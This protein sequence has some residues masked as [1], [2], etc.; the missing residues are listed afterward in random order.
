MKEVVQKYLDNMLTTTTVK[1][2]DEYVLGR[3]VNR[4][5][6]CGLYLN[7]TKDSILEKVEI[8]AKVKFKLECDPENYSQEIRVKFFDLLGKYIEEYGEPITSEDERKMNSWL[9]SSC[10]NYLCD[11]AKTMKSG[12]SLCN[13]ETGEFTVIQLLSLD[14]DDEFSQSLQGEVEEALNMSSKESFNYFRSWF[15]E[16]KSNILTKKQLAYL[17]DENL[18]LPNHRARINKT[19]SD[20]VYKQYTNSSI[21][22]YRI[23]KINHKISLLDKILNSSSER[24]LVYNLVKSMKTEE[25][26][27][28]S[29]YT[30]S[31]ETCAMVTSACKS[32][33]Y[34]CKKEC[35]NEIRQELYR[36]Y[37]YFLEII[38]R[39][40]KNL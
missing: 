34:T 14:S 4:V 23:D 7:S 38:E 27:T 20:R 24:Q 10:R 9:Y 8:M 16:N 32:V 18:I 30:L 22:Q 3:Y 26:L 5:P 35:V 36:L 12:A 28:E 25:W 1:E 2:G 31:F 37:M 11:I 33:E 40:K 39:L 15:N 29:I 17:E 13:R 6:V 21:I 19:I